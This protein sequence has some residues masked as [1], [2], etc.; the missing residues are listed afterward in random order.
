MKFFFFFLFNQKVHFLGYSPKVQGNSAFQSLPTVD[1]LRLDL[2]T[3]ANL[4]VFQ[5]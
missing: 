1:R 5:M 4:Q 3:T 2:C